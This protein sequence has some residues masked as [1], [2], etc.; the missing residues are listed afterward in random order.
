MNRTEEPLVRWGGTGLHIRLHIVECSP[1]KTRDILRQKYYVLQGDQYFEICTE[2]HND[3][4]NASD[5]QHDE[6]ESEG[7]KDEERHD[8]RRDYQKQ[9]CQHLHLFAD[10]QIEGE[11]NGVEFL[12]LVGNCVVSDEPCPPTTNNDDAEM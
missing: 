7:G 4:S 2:R 1:S 8:E 10:G 11:V 6:G 5:E 3:C 12:L 9:C